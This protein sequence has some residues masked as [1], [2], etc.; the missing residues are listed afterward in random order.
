M[1][2]DSLKIYMLLIYPVFVDKFRDLIPKFIQFCDKVVPLIKSGQ[3]NL[4]LGSTLERDAAEV[5][6]NK[7]TPFKKFHELL[8][9]ITQNLSLQKYYYKVKHHFDSDDWEI[10]VDATHLRD[11]NGFSV[12]IVRMLIN[13]IIEYKEDPYKML[14]IL[15]DY[16]DRKTINAPVY[17]DIGSNLKIEMDSAEEDLDETIKL[18]HRGE[19]KGFYYYTFA[20]EFMFRINHRSDDVRSMVET[21]RYATHKILGK[22]ITSLILMGFPGHDLRINVLDVKSY[23]YLMS[24]PY[25][26]WPSASWGLYIESCLH[27]VYIPQVFI[28]NR[29]PRRSD[30]KSQNQKLTTHF[31]YLKDLWA[32]IN[33]LDKRVNGLDKKIIVI[34][35]RLYQPAN[36]SDEEDEIISF[37][38]LL[39]S[40]LI[41]SNEQ[42]GLSHKFSLRASLLASLDNNDVKILYGFFRDFYRIRSKILQCKNIGE[43]E[44]GGKIP[45]L[46][47]HPIHFIKM[48]DP[49]FLL[50]SRII[51]RVFTLLLIKSE[52]KHYDDLV[53]FV[54]D[55][56]LDPNLRPE[57]FKI[58]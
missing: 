46:R 3:L 33:A 8:K 26:I 58:K 35:K 12:E 40:I 56:V 41:K 38:T 1:L 28:K 55:A 24:Y 30:K 47:F 27:N 25:P 51:K 11:I 16:I 54:D 23:R 14:N 19:D 20:T 48:I 49:P 52:I 15:S 53:D 45:T 42:D 5:F 36:I 37:S 4:P 17:I 7:L 43:L 2:A 44:M 31:K 32:Q 13:D 57:I 21:I 22:L 29:L 10:D 50:S 39:E 9:S 18:I 6:K 34:G